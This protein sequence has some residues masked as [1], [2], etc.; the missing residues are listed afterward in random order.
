V[1]QSLIRFHDKF[2]SDQPEHMN[3]F[4]GSTAEYWEA[5]YSTIC[6]ASGIT[7]PYQEF[8]L[9]ITELFTVEE[10]A[11]NPV[12]LRFLQFLIKFRANRRVLEIGTFIGV[13]AM[14]FARALPEGGEVVTIEKFDKF[15]AVAEEN[16]RRNGL[17]DRITLM[18]G[19][20][21]EIISTLPRDA[22]FDVA[23]IDG[24]KG[25]YLDY[26]RLVDPLIEVG[27]LIIVDDVFFHGDA[28]NA[29]PRTEKGAGVRQFLTAA[30]QAN[31][32][33]RLA[34]PISNGTMLMLKETNEQ[35]NQ[36]NQ[37]TAHQ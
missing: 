6:Q 30:A 33:L 4:Q 20:A 14:T 9:A 26:F 8:D 13:S 7:D 2:L 18:C 16:F 29:E 32:Y 21:H 24:D 3:E 1:S 35:N 17:T 5:L 15:A 10:M 31:N 36:P 37:E 19:D 22:L 27:G 12:L 28:I 34:L 11:S 23:F 25:R